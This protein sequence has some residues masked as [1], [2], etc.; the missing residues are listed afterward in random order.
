MEIYINS[1]K[2]FATDPPDVMY[3]SWLI[4]WLFKNMI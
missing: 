1:E 2:D 4:Y 3:D